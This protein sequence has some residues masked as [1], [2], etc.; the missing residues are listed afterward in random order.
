MRTKQVTACVLLSVFALS[1]GAFAGSSNNGGVTE[2]KTPETFPLSMFSASPK[3]V[4]PESLPAG[5][6]VAAT[7]TK[8]IKGGDTSVPYTISDDVRDASGQVLIPKGATGVGQVVQYKR[9]KMFGGPGKTEVSL[10]S[11]TTADGKQ[12]TLNS[13]STKYGS[14]ARVAT[15]L[16]PS[17]VGAGILGL[18]ITGGSG[19]VG[20]G[21]NLTFTAQ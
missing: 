7:I 8:D 21:T 17:F 4:K 1:N 16:V 20:T 19:K 6:K 5:T 12:F 15:I 11:I 3:K 10:D 2:W 18:F 13:K 14:D 9:P